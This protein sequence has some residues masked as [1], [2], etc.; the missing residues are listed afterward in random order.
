M[1]PPRFRVSSQDDATNPFPEELLRGRS[2]GSALGYHGTGEVNLSSILRE[3]FRPREAHELRRDVAMVDDACKR[4][5]I[6]VMHGLGKGLGALGFLKHELE[7]TDGFLR[8]YF[9][10]VYQTA[11]NYATVPGGEPIFGLVRTLTDFEKLVS[12]K[13]VYLAHRDGLNRRLRRL[14]AGAPDR[15]SLQV[16]L[17]QVDDLQGLTQTW[18]S[19]EPLLKKYNNS[20]TSNRTPVV[21]AI[22]GNPGWFG[23]SRRFLGLN[24]PAIAL[25]PPDS[26]LGFAVLPIGS[27]RR[28]PDL[29]DLKRADED[30]KFER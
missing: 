21:V 2:R 5:G 18:S 8:P 20:L 26:I 4:Y 19:L 10:G 16:S 6:G 24:A 27:T 14:P 1:F 13:T 11:R 25:I 22:A 9:T 29:S 15:A 17:D 23:S 7:M 30:A 12:D 3:G 28:E